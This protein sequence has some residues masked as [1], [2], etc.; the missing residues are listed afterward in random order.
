MTVTTAKAWFGNIPAKTTVGML[1]SFHTFLTTAGLTRHTVIGNGLSS[2]H[3]GFE[4]PW[5]LIRNQTAGY[6]IFAY[7][8][9]GY[10][11]S[12]Q[13][14]TFNGLHLLLDPTDSI[15]APTVSTSTPPTYA[16]AATGSSGFVLAARSDLSD[17]VYLS[18]LAY[19]AEYDD[20]ILFAVNN[21][22]N[23]YWMAGLH[24]G[25]IYV[26][27]NASDP[28]LGMEG[29]GVL[30]GAPEMQEKSSFS[31]INWC[32]TASSPWDPV[33]SRVKIAPNLWTQIGVNASY[34]CDQGSDTNFADVNDRVVLPPLI[35]ERR[36]TGDSS[37]RTLFGYSKYMRIYKQQGGHSAAIRS[38]GTDDQAWFR[39]SGVNGFSRSVILWSKTPVNALP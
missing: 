21:S 11:G 29:Y 36:V 15:V 23:T 5:I 18:G 33:Y 9:I 10:N 12:T 31:G 2:P 24:A 22:G 4:S 38:T 30:G 14:S 6:R 26:P 7:A 13:V 34:D 17:P 1:T 37:L 35:M 39:F 16:A 8:G 3:G 32:G 27:F 28:A 19:G 20:A 25:K